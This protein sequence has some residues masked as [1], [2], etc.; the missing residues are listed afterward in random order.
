[1]SLPSKVHRAD[2]RANVIDKGKPRQVG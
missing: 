1:M 2:T